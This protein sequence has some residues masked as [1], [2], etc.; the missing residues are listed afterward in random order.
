M[1]ENH[2]KELDL[3]RKTHEVKRAF[4]LKQHNTRRRNFQNTILA[5]E[6]KVRMQC[7]KQAI[8]RSRKNYDEENREKLKEKKLAS[9]SDGLKNVSKNIFGLEFDE[10]ERKAVDWVP[11]TSF[12]LDNS[13]KLVDAYKEVESKLD[14]NQ[15]PYGASAGENAPVRIFT[16]LKDIRKMNAREV[17][18]R[19]ARLAAGD[20]PENSDSNSGLFL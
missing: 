5:E 19:I 12:G 17:R 18:D 16:S 8:L 11:P 20:E 9:H 7:R 2:K 14:I 10:E 1:T 4:T 6:R 13:V 3:M 15:V